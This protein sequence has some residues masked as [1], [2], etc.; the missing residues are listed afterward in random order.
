M[1]M[2]R[3]GERIFVPGHWPAEV[4]NGATRAVRRGRL[5]RSTVDR[6]LTILSAYDIVVDARP[7]NQQW[8][9]ALNLIESYRLSAYDAAYLSL[10]K[11]LHV[12]LATFDSVLRLAAQAEGVRLTF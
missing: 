10:A 5:D 11:R 8:S 6:F 3:A 9:E 2:A 4:L 12:S 7:F 1:Q